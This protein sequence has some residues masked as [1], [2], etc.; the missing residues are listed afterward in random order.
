MLS[1]GEDSCETD[2]SHRLYHGG[3]WQKGLL[4]DL[5]SLKMGLWNSERSM[6]GEDDA[7][8]GKRGQSFY[9]GGIM[10]SHNRRNM[11]AFG[12]FI[13]AATAGY[14]YYYHKNKSQSTSA[15]VG[16]KP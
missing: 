3:V 7:A 15:A 8:R 16:N 13:V 1:E 10:Q 9:G 12:A 14:Y 6:M 4:I 5:F 2:E 11:M